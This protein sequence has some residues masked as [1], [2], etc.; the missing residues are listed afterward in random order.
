MKNHVPHICLVFAVIA[1]VLLQLTPIHASVF[2]RFFVQKENPALPCVECTLLVRVLEV[3]SVND[4]KPI[5]T[6]VD[7]LC[8][9]FGKGGYRDIELVCKETWAIFGPTIV[10]RIAEGANPDS[11]CRDISF[12][13]ASD[14]CRLLPSESGAQRYT[15]P[16]D[17]TLTE[18]RLRYTE[19]RSRAADVLSSKISEIVWPW[20]R[21]I[22]HMPAEDFDGD[23]FSVL[24]TLRGGDWRGKDCDDTNPNVYPGRKNSSMGP[25][26]DH[27]CNG[28]S[29]V[30]PQSGKSYEELFCAGVDQRG[31]VVLGDSASAHFSVPQVFT[32]G[33]QFA[34]FLEN[35]GDWPHC[36]W[37]TGHELDPASC[38]SSKYPVGPSSV[39]LKMRDRNRCNHRDFQTIAVNGAR[40]TA[41]VN[42]VKTFRRSP[43][44]DHP[45]L[46]FYLSAGNDVCNGH[47]DPSH[48]TTP[49]EFYAKV[50]ETLQYLDTILPAGSHIVLMGVEHGGMWD[51]TGPRVHPALN[52]TYRELWT[53]M[54][55]HDG[56]NPCYGWLTPNATY[57]ENSIRLA[58][59][60]SQQLELIASSQ[61]YE[62]FDLVYLENPDVINM[63]LWQ[64]AGGDPADLYEFVDG[65]H[66]STLA[67]QMQADY[68]WHFLET[69]KPEALGSVN[70]HNADIDRVF[71]AQGGY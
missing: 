3:A 31:V 36:S 54:D 61:K 25:N 18:G 56:I 5:D 19:L 57:R 50:T 10:R 47:W 60:Q 13:S 71:G 43:T 51:I 4:E 15:P 41:M 34:T 38:P 63:N 52:V 67:Q 16:T 21:V 55:C 37:A 49:Q 1:L 17:D 65:A 20:E 70:P 40:S 42:I 58:A 66:P 7:D 23:A 22:D 30:D 69:N 28:I 62:N 26:T 39:Y 45:V 53:F 32:S 44:N 35:E 59:A 8:S 46:M 68:A 24:E 9:L 12:C 29:G 33:A 14:S 64:A 11:I 48:Q 2:G 27:N 6:I